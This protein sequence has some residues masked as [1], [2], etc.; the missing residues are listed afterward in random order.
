MIFKPDHHTFQGRKRDY[1]RAKRDNID[2]DDYIDSVD[3][4]D[5]NKSI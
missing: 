1:T 2:D 5:N 4:I 3:N